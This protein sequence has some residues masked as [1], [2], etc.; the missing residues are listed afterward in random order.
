MRYNFFFFL[1]NYSIMDE[2][3]NI[4]HFNHYLKLFVQ[5]IMTT[6]SEYHD[7]LETYYKP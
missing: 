2:K 4:E 7:V 5:N 6:F 1:I 3:T